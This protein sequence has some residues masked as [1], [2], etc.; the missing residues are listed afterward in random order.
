[1]VTSTEPV[2]LVVNGDVTFGAAVRV[3]GMIYSRAVTTT[4]SGAGEIQGAWVAEGALVG[5]GAPTVVYNADV[6]NRLRLLYGSMV[7]VPG[8]WKDWQ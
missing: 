3:Y 6:L 5:T 8:S 1:V 7:K 2:L 4:T